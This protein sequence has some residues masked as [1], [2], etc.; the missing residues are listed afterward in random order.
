MEAD[1]W[2]VWDR[3]TRSPAKIDG[4]QLVRLSTDE[5]EVALSKLTGEPPRA[6]KPTDI[7]AN[8]EWQVTYGPGKT[9]PCIHEVDAKLLAR[10]LV[11]RGHSVSART[12]EG[13]L[14]ERLIW[15]DQI[16]AWLAE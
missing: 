16:R 2:M 15:P 13:V 14:P 9:Q 6:R 8:N 4:R 11:K 12:V 3:E 7:P 5:A 10:E 1:Y